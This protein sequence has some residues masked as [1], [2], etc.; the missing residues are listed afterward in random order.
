MLEHKDRTACER[1]L[2]ELRRMELAHEPVGGPIAVEKVLR[3]AQEGGK[4]IFDVCKKYG[5]LE[6]AWDGGG[7]HVTEAGLRFI[8]STHAD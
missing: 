6:G 3:G 4:R 8:A 1:F 5:L 2:Q 7:L